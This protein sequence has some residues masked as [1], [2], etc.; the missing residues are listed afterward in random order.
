MALPKCPNPNCESHTKFKRAFFELTEDKMQNS[1]MQYCLVSCV[2][3]GT[4]I[5]V[6][7]GFNS[8]YLLKRE[9]IPL[10]KSIESNK[11][12]INL[13]LNKQSEAIR[14]ILEKL[15]IENIV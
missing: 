1:E 10:L 5:G 15:N 14:L 12:N 11:A 3:C 8:G 13:E 4:V 9:A 6:V 2:T 7:E